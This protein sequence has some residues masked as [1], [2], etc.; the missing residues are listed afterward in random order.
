M[1][2]VVSLLVHFEIGVHFIQNIEMHEL[3][4]NKFFCCYPHA[5]NKKKESLAAI[6]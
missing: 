1:N 3:K 6:F 5:K 2:Q 4:M